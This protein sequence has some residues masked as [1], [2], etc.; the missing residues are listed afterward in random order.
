M[1]SSDCDRHLRY[2]SVDACRQDRPTDTSDRK[3]GTGGYSLLA[4]SLLPIAHDRESEDGRAALNLSADDSFL[5]GVHIERF[6]VRPGDD[7]SCLNLYQPQ[8]PKIV[9]PRAEFVASGRFAF[10]DSLA[11]TPEEKANR[12]ALLNRELEPGVV[13][14]IADANSMTYVLHR[15]LG[16]EIVLS[17]DGGPVR[18]KL[19]AALS[20]SIFQS[21][22]LMSEQ[23]FLRLFPE[24]QGYQFFL[25]DAPVEKS[26]EV[27]RELEDRLT[28]FGFDVTSTG[29]R[30]ASFN[31][32]ENTYL[33]TFQALGG[34]GLILGTVGLAAVLLRNVL[35]RRKEL[36]VLRAIG[37]DRA[38]FRVMVLAENSLLLVVGLLTGAACALL[39][40]APA[41]RSR[42]SPANSCAW[43]AVAVGISSGADCV[44]D[45]H[46]SG[47]AFEV[48]GGAAIRVDLG[49]A[50]GEH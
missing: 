28:D 21:E 43:G 19:V 11:A 15:K 20:H 6:R 39:A 29:D 26:A 7:T 30:L 2:R 13:P 10:Q 38:D 33:S 23:N 48:A 12:W 47:V 36:A 24:Q 18:L 44:A 17:T 9:A 46:S 22:L 34:L 14:V 16:D 42:R 32:V 50:S 37:Y 45:R 41:F 1:H 49:S 27:A 31:R 35:E 4:E 5:T 8:N 25:L 3:S 40:I